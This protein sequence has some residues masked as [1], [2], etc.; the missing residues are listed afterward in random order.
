MNV[1]F[2]VYFKAPGLFLSGRVISN[3]IQRLQAHRAHVSSEEL[4]GP[5]RAWRFTVA[6]SYAN[7]FQD[8][9][10]GERAVETYGRNR[11]QEED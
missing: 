2:T 5:N 7:A 1:D 10:H 9:L 11:K 6:E 8:A 3:T 4:A